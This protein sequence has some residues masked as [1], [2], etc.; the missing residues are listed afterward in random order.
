MTKDDALKKCS[1]YEAE[2]NYLR[3]KL[4]CNKNNRM[5]DILSFIIN[6]K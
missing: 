2:A 5:K 3:T 4:L 6:R 1:T